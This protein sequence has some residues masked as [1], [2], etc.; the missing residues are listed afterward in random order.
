MS[1]TRRGFL[2]TILT[3]GAAPA[4]VRAASLMPVVPRRG[5]WETGFMSMPNEFPVAGSI[6]IRPSKAVCYFNGRVWIAS[7]NTISCSDVCAPP[8]WAYLSSNGVM[9]DV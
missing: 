6:G 3:L 5:G 8:A 7:G 4:I 1:L 2:G 9:L